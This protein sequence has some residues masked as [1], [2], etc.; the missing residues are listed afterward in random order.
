MPTLEDVDVG[1]SRTAPAYD[2]REPVHEIEHLYLAII[3]AARHSVYI[4]SQYFASRKL[5][6]AIAER[7]R[8]PDGPE[9]VVV[10][11]ETADGW[12]EEEVMGSSRAK[13][14]K[15]IRK[16][17][18]YDRFKI[19]T[20]V[21]AKGTP[22]YVHAKVV[23]MDEELL[24]VGSSNLNNRSLG[25]DTECDLTVH[26]G[27]D[28]PRDAEIR[29]R[30]VRLRNSLIAEHLDVTTEKVGSAIKDADGKLI[31]AIEALRGAGRTLVPFVAPD[32][33]VAEDAVMAENELFDPERPA[34][35]WRPFK[36]FS[37]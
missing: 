14:L 24:R 16:A 29:K 37:R 21:A 17:D 12:L 13:L 33:N 7:L 5:A 8:E 35:R 18:V 11:P 25:M 10:N 27:E 1:I 6:E 15:L 28:D 31:G 19:Y 9:F 36:L 4:E 22:I 3:A 34:R 30:I 20:P 32:L 23:A 26:A 2:E